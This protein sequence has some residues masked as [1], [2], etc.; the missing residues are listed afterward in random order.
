M[1]LMQWGIDLTER[2]WVPDFMTRTV[3][4]RLCG[5]RVREISTWDCERKQMELERF[6]DSMRKGP[7]A[8]VPE[9]ANE[10]HYEVPAEFFG[11]VLGRHRKYSC[12][13]WEPGVSS[14]DAA[15][16]WALRLTCEHAELEDGQEILEL[17]CGWGS[18]SLWMGE[19]YPHSR[20]TAVSNSAVQREAIEELARRR[21]IDNV[22][23]ITADINEFEPMGV[24]DR[25]V[26]VEMFEH[27]RNHGELFRRI[28]GWLR[29]EGKL[30]VHIFCHKDSPYEFETEGDV[31]WMGRYFFTGGMM[32]SK[33]LPAR[34]QENL[35]LVRQ[36]NW[37]GEHYRKTAEAWLE[38]LDVH[39]DEVLK[40]LQRA[41]GI[42]EGR[43]WLQRWRMF[44]LAVAEL[45]GYR[46]GEE[47]WVTHVLF[48][49]Q[50]VQPRSE[51]LVGRVETGKEIVISAT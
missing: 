50:E 49:Q 21:G 4:R 24:F 31:N 13:Y 9:K 22:R 19:K 5:T 47:W 23:V 27:M 6:I 33:D 3:I 26:S 48:E 44:F 45:F 30:L 43:L 37:N 14:L 46:G 36:W 16:E 39:R 34:F 2:G 1:N 8:P 38:K 28:S 42:G 25:V 20:I 18:L 32:P 51:G 15:E 7:V 41:Y 11:K 10:Q 35:K 29:P 12:C 40:I 17:G